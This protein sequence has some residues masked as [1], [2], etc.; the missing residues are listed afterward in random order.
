MVS[1]EPSASAAAPTLDLDVRFGAGDFQMHVMHALNAQGI[2]GLFGQSGSGKTTLLRAIAGLDAG[3]SGRITFG[4]S[5]WLDTESQ[6]FKP[7]HR[8]GVGFVFQDTRLFSHLN[9]TGNLRFA[10][11]RARQLSDVRRDNTMEWDEVIE[12]LG[13]MPLMSRGVGGLSGGERQRVAIGRALLSRPSL[14]LFDEPLAALDMRRKS[15][16][17]P[18]LRAIPTR[19]GVPVIYVSHAI[20]EMAQLADD[21]LVMSA[22]RIVAHGAVESV[23]QR[24]DL[25]PMLGRF[26]AGVV[27]TAQ[28]AA[29]DEAYALTHLRLRTQQIRVPAV[30]VPIGSQVR[31]RIRARDVAL[32]LRPV[33]GLSIRNQLHGTI[34]D[35]VQEPSTAYAE[36]LVDVDGAFLR[37]RV[38]RLA[39]A[40]LGLEVGAPVV[41]LIKSVALD[42]PVGL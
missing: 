36:V 18:Y 33:T 37:A 42:R 38:T 7:A 14:M 31:L 8:R 35:L 28:V 4:S 30:A 32:A 27:L 41:A 11:R 25:G 6:V 2:T 34:R 24:M 29:H 21:M 23:L 39:V 19:F 22:G 10:E 15:E 9:V 13:L 16:I 1:S 5:L 40:E 20:D 12:A 3:V 17:L 26:E